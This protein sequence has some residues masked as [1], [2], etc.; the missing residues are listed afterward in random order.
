MKK[1]SQCSSRSSQ[2]C[3]PITA[4]AGITEV[5]TCLAK[6]DLVCFLS[7]FLS[8]LDQGVGCSLMRVL[9]FPLKEVMLYSSCSDSY[10]L[11]VVLRRRRPFIVTKH[12]TPNSH[13]APRF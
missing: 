10:A 9:A 5:H 12:H 13:R 3:D 4:S 2:T 6:I 11:T 8:I 7:Y 1:K